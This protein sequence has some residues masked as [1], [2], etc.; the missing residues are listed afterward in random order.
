MAGRGRMKRACTSG[1]AR[2]RFWRGVRSC[3]TGREG[4]SARGGG[5]QAGA[6]GR[7][8]VTSHRP[9]TCANKAG[10]LD[11]KPAASVVSGPPARPTP[12]SSA[13]F[14]CASASLPA[15]VFSSPVPHLT[16]DSRCLP[17]TN[18]TRR[19]PNAQRHEREQTPQTCFPHS[20][21][22]VPCC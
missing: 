19:A 20:S 5:L 7:R 12:S 18:V 13:S 15:R 1:K 14:P 21:R 4:P 9:R 16:L 2:R 22:S 8:A 3:Y 11:V 6:P 10:Q 17:S